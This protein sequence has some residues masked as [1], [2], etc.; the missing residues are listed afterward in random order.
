M[1]QEYS[2][3]QSKKLPLSVEL[4]VIADNTIVTFPLDTL[5]N[6]NTSI[7]LNTLDISNTMNNLN[8]EN[9]PN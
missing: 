3:K 9:G 7:T 2:I 8:S 5:N 4:S 6:S 1:A